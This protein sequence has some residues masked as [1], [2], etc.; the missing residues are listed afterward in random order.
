MLDLNHVFIV[1]EIGV[2]HNGSVELAKKMIYAAKAAGADAVKFQT[3]TAETLVSEGTPKVNYQKRTTG[4]A[5]SHFEMIKNLELPRG[6]HYPIIDYCRSQDIQFISTPYDIESAKFLHGIGIEVFKTASA[7][8]VDLPLHQFLSSTGK[9]VIISTGMAL[10]SEIREVL[11]LYK[12]AE[13]QNVILLHCVSNYPCKF[14]SLNLRVLHTLADEFGF[15]VG[16]SD[17][18]EGA[19]PAV[20]AVAMGAKVVEKHFTLD[21]SLDG[22]DH[23]ASSTPDEFREMVDAVRICELSL[24]SAVKTVQSE[25]EQM[26]LVSRKSIFVSR[27]IKEGSRLQPEDLTLKRPGVGLYARFLPDVLGKIA[28]CDLKEGNILSRDDFE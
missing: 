11:N 26:R 27:D 1:A 3:F 28:K 25:E 6:D 14:A 23:K 17:H 13:N 9:T 19:Y 12:S 2:N 4:E 8:I 15:P 24:G 10:L 16:Y 20:A 22:P 21:K 5:E 18:A 7:D